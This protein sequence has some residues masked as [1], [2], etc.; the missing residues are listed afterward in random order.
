MKPRDHEIL[1]ERKGKLE[2]RLARENL[3]EDLERPVL[4]EVN[5]HY[6]M[7]GRTQAT[8]CGGIAAIHKMAVRLGLDRALNERLRLLKVHLPYHESDHVL[9]MAYNVLAGGTCLE[10]IERLREDGAYMDALGAE[11]IPDPTTAGD[12]LRRF[13]TPGRVLELQETLNDV[14]EKVWRRQGAAF[15]RR[16]VVD[17]DGTISETRGEMKA[18]MDISYKGRWGYAPL[19][20]SLANTGEALYLVN[21]PGNAKS[22]SDAG[23]WIDRAIERVGRVFEEVVVRG[24]TDFSAARDLDRWAPCVT[25]YFGYDAYANLVERAEGLAQEAWK[26]LQ[27]APRYTVATRERARRENV[28]ERI[29]REREYQNIRLV[30]EHV[31]QFSYQP[32]RSEN[33]YRMVVLRKNLTVERGE[34]ALFDDLRYFFYITNDWSSS[35]ERAVFECNDRCNQEN[36]IAQHNAGGVGAFRMPV[37]DLVSNWAYMVIASLAWSLKAWW[38]MLIPNATESR[39]A[40]RM[41]FQSFVRRFVAIPCQIV[42]AGRRLVCRILGYSHHL[43]IFLRTFERIR[44]LKF[45]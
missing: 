17:V 20:I 37:G 6:E 32:A 8:G 5:V 1:E 12:F 7:S 10:D 21:R 2:L 40:L 34:L 18:G 38:A 33:T 16:A 22:S 24:D 42:R 27:R 35:A 28:K 44:R 3:G 39:A 9:N 19:I 43:A 13:E 26:A 41:E 15:L 23:R 25:F 29:V 11:R 4:G 36:L 14:R 31:A 30:S 45:T